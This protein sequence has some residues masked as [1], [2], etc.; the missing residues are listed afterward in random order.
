LGGALAVGASA[1]LAGLLW[2]ATRPR[3]PPSALHGAN[4]AL[5][6]RLRETHDFSRAVDAG[7]V[8]VLIVGGGAAALGAAWEIERKRQGKVTLFELESEVGGNARGGENAISR[9]PW[10]AHYVPLPPE[11]ASEVRE[12]FS[13]LGFLTHGTA[14]ARPTYEETSLCADPE[15]RLLFRGSWQEGLIPSTG[16]SSEESTEIDA[17]FK[18]LQELKV[19]QGSDGKKAFAIPVDRS[20]RD[21]R[22]LALDRI[23]AAAYLASQGWKT[24]PLLWYVDYCCRDDYGARAHQVSAWAMLHYFAARTGRATNAEENWL[25]TWPDGNFEI[26]RRLRA[27]L[28]ARVET[29]MAALRIDAQKG[30]VVAWSAARSRLERVRARKI[31]CCTPRFI[32]RRLLPELGAERGVLDYSPWSVA[33]ISLRHRP[34]GP[35]AALAWDNVRYGSESLGYVVASHQLRLR[36]PPERTVITHYWPHSDQASSET[37]K[38][39][40][41]ASPESLSARVLEDLER[42]HPGI[43]AD[44]LSLDHWIWGHAM[45]RPVPGWIW[46]E[47]RVKYARTIGRVSFAHSDLGGSPI[48]EEAFTRGAWAARDV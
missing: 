34:A 23:S 37:R 10:G 29:G 46:G 9:Y 44:V 40:L 48:F 22:F 39:L 21:P 3:L 4:A 13:D 18:H 16:L 14:L 32:T 45:L 6:H 28:Q 25:L 26:I 15:D 5:G 41:R 11:S 47:E 7:E 43:R 20:S 17:F 35:G 19:A 36:Y 33:N 12:L 2:R 24:A 8:D 30:E 31:L 38:H 1:G 27:K 42:T